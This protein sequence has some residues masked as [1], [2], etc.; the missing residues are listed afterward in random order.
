MKAT[1]VLV[2]WAL[3]ALTAM[4]S[5]DAQ[6]V[7]VPGGTVGTSSNSNVGIGTSSPISRLDVVGDGSSAVVLIARSRQ[8]NSYINLV[9]GTADD[10]TGEIS[11]ERTGS[12]AGN[13]YIGGNA[14]GNIVFRSG[15][16]AYKMIIASSG[17]VGIGTSSPSKRLTIGTTG[18]GAGDYAV[19]VEG[20]ENATRFAAIGNTPVFQGGQFS[21]T[22]SSKSATTANSGLAWFQGGGFDGTTQ[23][24]NRGRMVVVAAANW[25]ETSTPTLL[26]F[27]TTPA[28]GVAAV[29]RLIVSESGNLGIGTTTPAASVD[30]WKAYNA[31]TDSLRFSYNDGTAYWMGIQ[32][33]VVG[34]G[35]VGYKIRTNNGTTTSDSFAITG[36]GNVGIGTLYPTQKLSVNGTVRAKEVIVDTGWSDHVFADDY[37]LASLAE[38]EAH[39]R[40]KRHLPG[41]PTAAEV[42][43]GGVSLGDMQAKLLAKIEELT[44][45]QIEQEKELKRLRAEVAT[46]RETSSR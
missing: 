40:E 39:I 46:I 16:Y 35:N 24:F 38:V 31:G 11:F 33:Y 20:D 23:S 4:L 36:A 43:E 5:L 21:G 15:G 9:A 37:Q 30:I 32:P 27:Q 29:E 14:A 6:T 22:L 12:T 7:Y 2:R 17:N 18:L 34:G 25:T 45:H 3:V 13:I 28:G 44:L 42:T 19:L 8:T 26:S 41:I 1:Y 10:A